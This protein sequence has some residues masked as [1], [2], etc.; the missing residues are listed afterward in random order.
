MRRFCTPCL[1]SRRRRLSRPLSCVDGPFPPSLSGGD[2]KQLLVPYVRVVPFPFFSPGG[3][4]SPFR[5]DVHPVRAVL[6]VI[7]SFLFLFF[8]PRLHKDVGVS[9]KRV[10]EVSTAKVRTEDL[11]FSPFFLPFSLYARENNPSLE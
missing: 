11:V 7:D 4:A 8:L 6:R 3:E 5:H 2:G 10:I 9:W 1:A